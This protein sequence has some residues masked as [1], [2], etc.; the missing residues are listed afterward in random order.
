MTSYAS[1]VS[2]ELSWP[3]IDDDL[4]AYVDRE[5][6]ADRRPLVERHLR[7]HAEPCAD[8]GGVGEGSF[9]MRVLLRRSVAFEARA[10]GFQGRLIGGIE[11]ILQRPAAGAVA[12][13]DHLQH[14]DGGNLRGGR[15]DLERCVIADAHGLDIETLG[16]HHP[17]QLLDIPYKTPLIS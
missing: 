8:P 5:L 16:L 1:R 15:E 13:T 6:A 3:V 10:D 4:H 2:S 9:G 7:D 14:L 17:E 11:H 12:R